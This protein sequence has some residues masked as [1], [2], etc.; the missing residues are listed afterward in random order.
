MFCIPVPASGPDGSISDATVDAGSSVTNSRRL[1]S[2]RDCRRIELA[3]ISTA[4]RFPVKQAQSVEIAYL[5]NGEVVSAAPP[6]EARRMAGG[7]GRVRVVAGMSLAAALL[8]GGGAAGARTGWCTRPAYLGRVAARRASARPWPRPSR[9]RGARAL[10]PDRRRHRRRRV[11]GVA[12]AARAPDARRLRDAAGAGDDR[13][14]RGGRAPIPL[15]SLIGEGVV[16]VP[17]PADARAEVTLG[18]ATFVV[19]QRP[20]IADRRPSFPPGVAAPVRAQGAAAARARG[21]GERAAAP[22]RTGAQIGEADMRSAIP[23]ARDAAGD[24]E[25]AARR[26]PDAGAR[27]APVLRRHADQLP[28][29]GLRRRELSLSRDG[30]DSRALDR[31]GPRTAPDC[32]VNECLSDVVATWFF[33]P[34]PRVDEGRSC[35]CRSCGPTSRC[36]TARRAPPRTSSAR[37]RARD[38]HARVGLI[39]DRSLTG[40]AR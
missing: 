11:L 27:A 21:A 36:R 19:S 22:V 16:D 24:R 29:A 2:G 10:L 28:E 5:M 18:P 20:A 30:R 26:G 38:A 23:A 31:A 13:A 9:G 15:E 8:V 1:T 25:A 32:P 7:H 33:E 34:L 17:L 6:V 40:G 3:D 37:R 35:R 14:A 39:D 4:A 12:A